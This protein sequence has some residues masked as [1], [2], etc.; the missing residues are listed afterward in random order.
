MELFKPNFKVKIINYVIEI[1]VQNQFILERLLRHYKTTDST[2]KAFAIVY[3]HL[4]KNIKFE[5]EFINQKE[6]ILTLDRDL[7][8]NQI[9]FKIR[10]LISYILIRKKILLLH[11]SS[12]VKDGC[13]YIFCGRSGIGK[14][15][16]L[17]HVNPQN[18]ISDDVV[19][20]AKRD[21]QFYIFTSP[22]DKEKY[23]KLDDRIVPLKKIF[24][25]NR[26]DKIEFKIIS[27]TDA[28]KK[29]IHNNY[30]YLFYHPSKMFLPDVYKRLLLTNKIIRQTE[31][32]KGT[33][34][35]SLLL[36]LFMIC[37]N[38][39][40]TVEIKQL[41]CTKDAQIFDHL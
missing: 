16:I 32:R 35:K 2:K 27:P 13:G 37:Y 6:A 34:P 5:V 38:F 36:L 3:L 29:L 41:N 20:L 14:S 4:S 40:H 21:K 19:V 8:I 30:L 12:I 39:L 25:L 24:F 33:V 26:A 23:P 18:V 22:F 15:T 31:K 7:N 11:G 28:F 10:G 9:N 1:K 17:R